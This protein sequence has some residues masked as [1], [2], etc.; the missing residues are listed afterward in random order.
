[1][2][3]AA[4]PA[5]GTLGGLLMAL[6]AGGL[7]EAE[8]LPWL[9][10]GTDPAVPS[11]GSRARVEAALRRRPLEGAPWRL[12]AVRSVVVGPARF[13]AGLA[14]TDSKAAVHFAAFAGLLGWLWAGSAAGDVT[15]VNSD[16]HGGRHYYLGPLA[17][18]LPDAWIEPGAEGPGLSAYTARSG[19]RRLELAL[20]PR[21]DAADGLVA[22][23]SIV[24]KAV[25][26][27]WMAAFNDHWTA[28]VPG[29][30]PTAGYPGDAARFRAAI[31][32]ECRA[33]GLATE[34]WWRA[35]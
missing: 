20:R 5:P 31:E 23:A 9:D 34:R 6:G 29:L 22:L 10:E 24:S 14:A 2:A 13:N 4:G 19:R 16:K 32:P 11:P 3:A 1:V 28:R 25:R 30:R 33:R 21:A 17:E 15:R 8:L 18:A 27:R 26:E 12:V 35:R 7:V